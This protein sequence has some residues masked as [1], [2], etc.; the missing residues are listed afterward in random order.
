MHRSIFL[1]FKKL[2]NFLK[3]FCTQKVS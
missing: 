3:S 1:Q 2:C